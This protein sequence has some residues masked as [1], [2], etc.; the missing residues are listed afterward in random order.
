M[1]L[2]IRVIRTENA[3]TQAFFAELAVHSF[4]TLAVSDLIRRAQIGK[5]TFY[6]HYVDKFDLAQSIIKTELAPVQTLLQTRLAT[7]TLDEFVAPLPEAVLTQV[8]HLR[9]LETIHTDELDFDAYVLAMFDQVFAARMQKLA[10]N[11]FDQKHVMHY[12]TTASLSLFK[13]YLLDAAPLAK[14]LPATCTVLAALFAEM[15]PVVRD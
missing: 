7:G 8:P 1:P 5:G 11:V 6:N 2:D 15:R 10:V 13:A 12:I 4:N 9:L 3:I 14:Q